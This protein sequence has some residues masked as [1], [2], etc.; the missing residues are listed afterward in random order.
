MAQDVFR[1][2]TVTAKLLEALH[3]FAH[4]VLTPL[5]KKH[6]SATFSEHQPFY[7]NKHSWNYY[8]SCVNKV[9]KKQWVLVPKTAYELM[10]RQDL[11][12]R[13]EVRVRAGSKRRR[14]QE[15]S[16]RKL[17]VWRVW[18]ESHSSGKCV[19]GCSYTCIH[20]LPSHVRAGFIAKRFVPFLHVHW[21]PFDGNRERFLPR[22]EKNVPQTG[23]DH[24]EYVLEYER[25]LASQNSSQNSGVMKE[26]VR[27]TGRP[28]LQ[29]PIVAR[30]GVDVALGCGESVVKSTLKHKVTRKGRRQRA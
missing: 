27:A 12:L 15:R 14:E 26:M 2:K 13:D 16:S 19:G 18:L 29:K 1:N 22:K 20:S 4:V 10:D 28:H 30:A 21:T 25:W 6:V 11:L 17:P 8:R 5:W 23:P 3:Q 9:Y 7:F 24:F